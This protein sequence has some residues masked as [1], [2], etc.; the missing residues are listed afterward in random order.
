[1]I[2]NLAIGL[3]L[4]FENQKFDPEVGDENTENTFT[5]GPFARYYFLENKIKPFLEASVLFGSTKEEDGNFEIKSDTFGF[6][7]G[8]G[9]AIFLNKNISID[10]GLAY[11]N[12]K[13]ENEDSDTEIKSNG[14]GAVVGF[15][16]F[17]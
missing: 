5:I 13:I 14:I 9:V 1:M 6:G 16:L 10:F 2:D 8:A 11:N 15:N 4:S 12:L 17:F 3:T 7:I